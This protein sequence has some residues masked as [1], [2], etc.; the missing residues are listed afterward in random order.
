MRV[1]IF[2]KNQSN[3]FA[4]NRCVEDYCDDV[5]IVEDFTD[6]DAIPVLISSS[7]LTVFDMTNPDTSTYFWFGHTMQADSR[8]VVVVNS[9]HDELFPPMYLALAVVSMGTTLGEIVEKLSKADS[10]EEQALAAA[11]IHSESRKRLVR[12]GHVE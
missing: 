5:V 6:F 9:L 3:I 10:V 7:D 2:S 1:S 8:V 12:A 11:E 4:L